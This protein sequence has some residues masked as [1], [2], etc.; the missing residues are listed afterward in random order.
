MVINGKEFNSL[1]KEVIYDILDKIVLEIE[2]RLSDKRIHISLTDSARQYIIDNS[3]DVNFGARPI[4]RFVQ[5]NVETL[6][7]KNIILDKIKVNSTVTIDCRDNELIIK[8]LY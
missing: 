5:R 3:Y 7:A 2:Q 1:S 6:I 4:K 8:E